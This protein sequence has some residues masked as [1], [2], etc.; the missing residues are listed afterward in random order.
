MTENQEQPQDMLGVDVRAFI[1]AAAAKTPT[2]GGGSVAGVVGALGVALGEMA[3][4]FTMGKKKYAEHAEY[5]EHLAGRLIK[6][7]QMFQDLV[8]D[9]MAAFKLYQQANRQEDGPAKDEAVQ[10]ATAAAIDVPREAAKLAL[11]L[12]QDMKELAGKCNPWLITDLLASCALAAATTRLCDYNTRI[13]LPQVADKDK[14]EQIRASSSADC[15]RARQ[16]L[17]EIE[18]QTEHLLS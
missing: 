8:A 11:A 9:D 13:N 12:L 4:N 3:L 1:A 18:K 15:L 5:H 10:L 17:A 14:A 2:P 16:M 6:A 7:R